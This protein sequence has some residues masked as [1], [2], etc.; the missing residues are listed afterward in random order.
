MLNSLVGDFAENAGFK[1]KWKNFIVPS[2]MFQMEGLK[3][4]LVGTIHAVAPNGGYIAITADRMNPIPNVDKNLRGV[5]V[6]HDNMGKLVSSLDM[7]Y[8]IVGMEF[9]DNQSLLIVLQTGQF[10]TYNPYSK[11]SSSLQTIGAEGEMARD[12]VIALKVSKNC[13]LYIT[14]SYQ[15]FVKELGVRSPRYKLYEPD[16]TAQF[17]QGSENISIVHATSSTPLQIFVP[18]LTGGLV[19][20][21]HT[22]VPKSDKI[23]TSI[24]EKIL[25]TSVSPCGHDLAVLTASSKLYVVNLLNLANEWSRP[26]NLDDGQLS[27]L[28]KLEWVAFYS[29]VLV[30]E[31]SLKFVCFGQKDEDVFEMRGELKDSEKKNCQIITKSEIDGLRVIRIFKHY[32]NQQCILFVHN[33]GLLVRKLTNTYNSF[34]RGGCPASTLLEQYQTYT[35]KQT[36]KEDDLRSDKLKLIE[37]VSELIELTCFELD[38]VR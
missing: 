34:K 9:L 7:P 15:I 27:S 22:P 33:S 19:R 13:F 20:I 37:A 4:N 14:L 12:P 30:F 3:Y 6:V 31:K 5:L 26:L 35:A 29:V 36:I 8:V 11:T 1:G 25:L 28:R 2:D 23:L 10:F 38:V 17:G 18:L 24:N 16:Q 21:L 32:Q